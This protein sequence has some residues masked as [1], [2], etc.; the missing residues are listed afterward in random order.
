[1]TDG[2]VPD[3]D[4]DSDSDGGITAPSDAAAVVTVPL[5]G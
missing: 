5:L 4:N 3:N 1:M 2:S